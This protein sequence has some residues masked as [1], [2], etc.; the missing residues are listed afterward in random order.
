MKIDSTGNFPAQSSD[1][2][3]VQKIQETKPKLSEDSTEIP[4]VTKLKQIKSNEGNMMPVSEKV[5]LEAIEKANRAIEGGN[6]E[7]RISVHE[8]THQISIKIIDKDKNEVIREIPPEKILDMVA[9]MM[10]KAGIIVDEK[11]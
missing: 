3:P 1:I 2:K 5:V 6:T 10:E 4:S 9:R 11:R 8:K 7:L